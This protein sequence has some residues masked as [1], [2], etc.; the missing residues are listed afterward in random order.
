A[1]HPA[2]GER[3][4][5]REQHPRRADLVA[6]PRVRGAREEAQR[7]DERD[8]RQEVEQV[9]RVRVHYSSF[10]RFLNISSIRSVTTKPPT[11]FADASTTAMNP[12]T[13]VNGPLWPRPSTSIAPTITIPWIAFVP[14]INGVC[15]SVGTFE[16]TSKPRKIASTRIVTSKT[17]SVLWLMPRLLP[18]CLRRRRR[19]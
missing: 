6:A 14:D 2:L 7:E 5:D 18:S 12:I 1:R 16:I 15:S 10:W 4:R 3:D 8:D 17:R 13:Q 19:L 9:R 11:T